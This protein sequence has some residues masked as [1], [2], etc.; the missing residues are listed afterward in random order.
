MRFLVLFFFIMV[1]VTSAQAA[2]LRTAS[3]AGYKKIVEQWATLYE[4]TTGHKAERI[5]GNMGQISAQV[6]QGGGICLVVGDKSYLSRAALPIQS[7]VLLGQGRPVLVSRKGLTLSS[8]ADLAKPEFAR[9]SAPDYQ[10]AIYGRAAHQILSQKQYLGILDKVM[11]VGTVPR[12]GAYA[13][14]GEVDAAFVNMSFAMANKDKFGSMLELTAGFEAIEIV[15]GII[16]GC[17]TQAEVGE[18]VSLLS[19]DS[20][21]ANRVAAGL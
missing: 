19:S 4:Q 11:P 12:S 16:K 17:E 8:V 13:I 18:F 10:K 7:F 21:Q 2:V 3:G 20:M 14:S 9:I 5:Y 6:K 1:S 15:A